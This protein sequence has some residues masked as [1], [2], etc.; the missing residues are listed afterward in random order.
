MEQQ[1]NDLSAVVDGLFANAVTSFTTEQGVHVEFKR[2]GITQLGKASKFIELVM[3]KAD[4]SRVKDFLDLITG[5]Q[6]A[7]MAEGKS[8]YDINLN[9]VSMIEK[10]LGN[11]SLLLTIFAA[12]AE[13]IPEF[14]SIFSTI[15]PEQFDQCSLDE[16]MVMAA[17]VFIVNYGFFTQSLPPIIKSVM[18][19]LKKKHDAKMLKD[20]KL[21]AKSLTINP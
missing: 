14:V 3:A 13:V 1:S 21:A 2:A 18:Q 16:Q 5:E 7:L 8:V 15:T 12:T 19:G 20:G 6:Q 17:G 9:A 11:Q 10:F 4:P